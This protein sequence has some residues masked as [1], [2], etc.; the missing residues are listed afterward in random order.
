MSHEPFPYPPAARPLTPERLADHLAELAAAVQ[1]VKDQDGPSSLAIA[2]DD[3]LAAVAAELDRTRAELRDVLEGLRQPLSPS[4]SLDNEYWNG[5]GDGV[6]QE[7][8]A[9]N[10]YAAL[11]LLENGFPVG[12]LPDG[13]EVPCG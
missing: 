8:R 3:A 4:E 12:A 7:R 6:E 9:T 1:V 10:E 13:R 2:A 5:F 11:K